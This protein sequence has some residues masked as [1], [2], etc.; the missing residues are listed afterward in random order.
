METDERMENL[1]TETVR[2][3][4]EI[5]SLVAE[6]DEFKVAWRASAMRSQPS[7]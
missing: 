7:S 5:L 3:T 2:I 6:I 4:I 1:N